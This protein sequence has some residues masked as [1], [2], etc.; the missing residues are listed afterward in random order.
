M[1]SFHCTTGTLMLFLSLPAKDKLGHISGIVHNN[2]NKE[3]GKIMKKMAQ[4]GFDLQPCVHLGR[5][6]L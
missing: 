6:S 1:V 4:N 3:E 5:V 2:N